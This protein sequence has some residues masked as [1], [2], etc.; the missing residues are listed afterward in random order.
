MVFHH[1]L[2]EALAAWSHVAILRSLQD[3][4]QGMTG[5]EI[6][7]QA[8]LSHQ[9]CDR[10]LA[11]LEKLHI[12][13][14]QRGG[15]SHFFTL[16]RDHELV[17]KALLSLLTTERE[18]FPAFCS[19]INK[20]IGKSALSIILFGSV[21]RKQEKPESDIDLCFVVRRANDKAKAQAV[22]H[23]LEP[24]M[25]QRFGAKLSPI[26]FTLAEFRQKASQHAPPVA[27]I[28][29]EGVVISGLGLRELHHG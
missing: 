8:G 22:V 24:S 26:F 7:R 5:R 4:A 25:L 1:V 10:A 16:N 19:S 28:V 6:A 21:A 11:R 14:R 18:F 12:L 9:T 27:A 17:N 15:R 3:A 2:D 23:E 20:G 29:K 13:Q